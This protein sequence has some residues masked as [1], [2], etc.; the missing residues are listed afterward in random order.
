VLQ[1]G[2]RLSKWGPSQAAMQ[3]AAVAKWI[4]RA[5]LLLLRPR[6]TTTTTDVIKTMMRLPVDDG[7]VASDD[8]A[9]D[10]GNAHEKGLFLFL[11]ASS[12]E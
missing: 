7:A 1:S 3:S 11:S 8:A 4:R 5:F 12:G 2:H 10:D 9:V 6:G